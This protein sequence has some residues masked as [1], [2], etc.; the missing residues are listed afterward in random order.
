MAQPNLGQGKDGR[1]RALAARE[2]RGQRSARATIATGRIAIA[3]SAASTWQVPDTP[4][5]GTI[6]V[7]ATNPPKA[8]PRKR[9][10][11]EKMGAD[12]FFQHDLDSVKRGKHSLSP[13]SRVPVFPVSVFCFDRAE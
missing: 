5:I 6:K 11:T 4:R 10:K 2:R 7:P 9:K 8:P 12:H 1:A 3:A 13:F